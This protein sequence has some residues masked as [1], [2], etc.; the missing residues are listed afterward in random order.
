MVRNGL[1]DKIHHD[2]HLFHD[3]PG[4]GGPE[5]DGEDVRPKAAQ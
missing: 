3:G 1:V 2:I 5:E 4:R